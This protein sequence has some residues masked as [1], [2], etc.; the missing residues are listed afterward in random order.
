MK[1]IKMRCPNC[2]ADLSVD[3]DQK[4][5][6]CS[7]CGT[8]ILLDDETTTYNVNVKYDQNINQHNYDEAE[9]KRLEYQHEIDQEKIKQKAAY[10]EMQLQRERENLLRLQE[11]ERR[12]RRNTTIWK[13]CLFLYIVT[14]VAIPFIAMERDRS[15]NGTYYVWFGTIIFG[16]I[17]LILFRPRK[18]K[19]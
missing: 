4:I 18:P 17:L 7:Y 3:S 15:N 16:L 9:L 13:L 5:C 12:N 10:E 19:K 6:F 2:N 8:R 11:Q 1:M 14:I